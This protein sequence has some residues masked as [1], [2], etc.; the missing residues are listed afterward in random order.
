MQAVYNDNYVLFD[1]T[2]NMFLYNYFVY[3]VVLV[4]VQDYR[5]II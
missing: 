5:I 1:Y 4:F 3:I 2:M